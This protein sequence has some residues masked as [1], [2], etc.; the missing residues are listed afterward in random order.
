MTKTGFMRGALIV[1]SILILIG[2]AIMIWYSATKDEKNVI[3]VR[4]RSGVTQSVTFDDLTLIPG[5]QRDYTLALKSDG[6]KTCNLLIEFA[7]LQD[8]TLK[9]YARVK[10]ESG[11]TVICD[12]LL[13]DAFKSEPMMLAVDFTDD[14][15]TE[16]KV[17][18]YIPIE[19]GNEAQ[20]AEAVFEM[21]FTATNE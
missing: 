17:T 5:E 21:R 12:K 13:A 7:E 20:N 6:A 4:L 11:G 16:L 2:V 10:L 9:Y 18:Y 15:N 19:V 3:E 8:L 1:L 14:K